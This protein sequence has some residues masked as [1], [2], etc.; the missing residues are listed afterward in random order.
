[1]TDPWLNI[2]FDPNDGGSPANKQAAPNC[3]GIDKW[4]PA[5]NWI[6]EAAITVKFLI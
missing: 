6:M 2:S 5:D 3:D 4:I 1:M